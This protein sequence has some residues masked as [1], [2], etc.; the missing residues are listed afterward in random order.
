MK[1]VVVGG[2]LRVLNAEISIGIDRLLVVDLR[3]VPV[4]DQALFVGPTFQ[5]DMKLRNLDFM[6][7]DDLGFGGEGGVGIFDD[8]RAGIVQIVRID[9][10]R[11]V[12]EIVKKP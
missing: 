8:L 6:T 2:L 1:G 9:Q 7:R 3:L 11:I 4:E 5:I 12:G 10:G